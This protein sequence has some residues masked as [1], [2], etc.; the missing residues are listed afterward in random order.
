MAMAGISM[1]V[2]YGPA[3]LPRLHEV[4]VDGTVV[5]FAVALSLVAGVLLGLL[6]MLRFGRRSFAALL[7]DGG[8]G[9][10]RGRDRHRVRQLLIVGQVAMALVLLVG[11][12]LMLQSVARL[13]AVDPGFRI[14][15]LLT[16]G[17]SLG[18]QPDRARAVAFYHSALDEVAG[19]PGVLSVGASN[20]L[21]IYP[22]GMSGSSIEIESRP[23]PDHEI[24]PV[25][26]Y[27]AVTA[28]YFETLGMPL[29]E[30]RAPA[31]DDAERGRTVVWVNETFAR[32]FLDNRAV[33]ERI[34]IGGTT[35]E[36]AGVVGDVRFDLR[37]DV[38]PTAYLPLHTPA[39][40]LDVMHVVIRTTAS[41]ASLAPALRAA[42]GR[43]D[44]SVP[45]TT[46]RTLED[47][48]ASSLARMSFTMTLLGIA[49]S[50]ALVL[51][52]VGLYGVIRYIVS[53]RTSEIGVR[54][55]LG[56]Q[57]RDVRTMVLRQGVAVALVGVIVG[58]VAAAMSTRIMAS[59]LF[60]VSAR[61]PVTF[62][63]VALVLTAVSA[64]ATYVPA[65][66]AAGIDPLEAL[67]E[68]G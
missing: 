50:L 9:S 67:R 65:R 8:R 6:P 11:S 38:R 27:Q 45:L 30:G 28:G 1:L 4:S 60:G 16:A 58:L 35:L 13:Y 53:Q 15:G 39:V 22:D 12:G 25:A 59:L 18:D 40:A 43:V 3:E 63:A 20:R 56:A 62:G 66:R 19:L 31:R 17:V 14:E 47:V 46:A 68:E 57:P 23:R 10:T 37:E 21:P 41:R 5:A 55:A 26:M 54:L 52:V 49:A 44:P 64:L 42:V 24:P 32:Q 48:V 7:R 33:G 29:L 61:D 51:G 36:I 34:Q 2:A